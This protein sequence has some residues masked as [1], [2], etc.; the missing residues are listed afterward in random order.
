[1]IAIVVCAVNIEKHIIETFL[2]N[3][4]GLDIFL[5]VEKGNKQQYENVTTFWY[6]DTLFN[7]G[8]ASNIAINS[9]IEKGY[10]IIVKSDIDCILSKEVIALISKIKPN[11][12]YCFRYWQVKDSE[13]ESLKYAQIDPKIHGTVALHS[14]DWKRLRGYDERLDGYG[15]DDY[16]MTSRARKFGI[17]VPTLGDPRLYHISHPEKHNCK[18][19]N[20]VRRVE[21]RAYAK[22]EDW[23]T[24]KER[25]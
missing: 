6:D 4:K 15:F 16:H 18:T 17:I 5:T 13:A 8:K 2:K 25:S 3:H 22:A 7:I 11:Q 20:P 10:D 1:M 24:Y 9:A 12:G 14:N 21:N 23:A 19:T